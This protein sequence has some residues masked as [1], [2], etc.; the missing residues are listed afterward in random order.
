M[1]TNN[2]GPLWSSLISQPTRAVD[3]HRYLLINQAALGHNNALVKKL[4]KFPRAALLGQS[5]DACTDGATPFVLLWD[6][7]SN[8]TSNLRAIQT[9]CEQACYAC[10]VSVLDSALGI[11][12][13]ATALTARCTVVLPDNLSMLLRYFDTRVMDALVD[14]LTREQLI[15]LVSCTTLW[16]YAD[17]EGPL[18][19]FALPDRDGQDKFVSPLVL[20]VKQQNALIDA[21]EPDF[22]IS[23]LLN[24]QIERLLDLPMPRRYSAISQ[25]IIRARTF[26]LTDTPDFV[27]YC[28]LA[29]SIGADFANTAPWSELLS[30]VKAKRITFSE[31]LTKA[32]ALAQ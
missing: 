16:L 26:G 1:T 5:V 13:L 23:Q 18:N 9:L 2:F 17:R 7:W 19:P 27:A 8:D 25:L 10:A 28:A 14:V 31:A 3:Q 11:D 30:D 21:G 32:E 29:L 12:Q 22:V 4:S 15:S 20:S 24:A 6:G